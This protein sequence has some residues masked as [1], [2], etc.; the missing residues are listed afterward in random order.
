MKKWKIHVIA[1]THW[2]REWFFSQSRAN[3]LFANNIKDIVQVLN[4][5]PNFNSFVLDGQ[6]SVLNDYFKEFKTLKPEIEKLAKAKRLLLGP[7]YSQPDMFSSLGETIIRNLEQGISI[8]NDLGNCLDIAY[9]PDSFGFNANLPQ[10]F[11]YFD[12]KKMIF[13]RGM[14]KEDND[15]TIFFN[16][17]GIDGSSIPA[18]CY[19]SGYWMFSSFFPYHKVTK[20]NL[21]AEAKIIFSKALP[22]LKAIKDRSSDTKQQILFP[23]GQDESP[24]V[25]LLPELI[26][27]LN[28]LD[29]ENEWIMSDFKRFFKAL[30]STPKYEISSSL[31]WPYVARIHRTITTSRYDIK[32][33]FRENEN[34]IYHQLEPLQI[35]YRQID[36]GYQNSD[37]VNE[38]LKK[39]LSSQAHDSLGSCNSDETNQDIINRL[40]QAKA[41]IQAE[42]DI[43]INKIYYRLDLNLV[44]DLLVFNLLPYKRKQLTISRTINHL[45]PKITITGASV[46]DVLTI[47]TQS[48]KTLASLNEYFEHQ[49]SFQL[50][51]VA[52]F[53][54]QV[55]KIIPQSKATI[56]P[57]TIPLDVK[58]KI[59]INEKRIDYF[60]KTSKLIEN[61]FSIN[62]Y[63]DHGD[64]YDFSPNYKGYDSRKTSSTNKIIQSI[65]KDNLYYC[66]FIHQ[67]NYDQNKQQTFM[68][69]IS[70]HGH[71]PFDLKITTKNQ[72]V[73][74]KWM[75][76]FNLDFKFNQLNDIFATQ[77]LAL[78]NRKNII[79]LDWIK[80]GYKENPAL[81]STNDGLIAVPKAQKFSLLT[82]ANNEYSIKDNCLTITLFR[83]YDYLGKANLAWRPGRLSGMHMHTPDALLQKELSFKF[84]F[85]FNNNNYPK[86]LNDWFFQPLS[87]YHNDPN[88][89]DSF[90]DRFIVNYD[91]DKNLTDFKLANIEIDPNFLISSFRISQTKNYELR[92]AN[93]TKKVKKFTLLINGKT[94]RFI[95]KDKYAKLSNKSVDH[96]LLDTQKFI[97]I[98]FK[99]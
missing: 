93:L 54:Y 17:K 85:G 79:E 66:K 81:L 28:L 44:T 20:N 16:W 30:P 9:L 75:L 3:T 40:T 62:P 74:T 27:I 55:L 63:D 29:V 5:H 15:K 50:N 82:F 64:G 36:A 84:Q 71:Q 19:N 51:D 22:I 52:P 97:T 32:Q 26:E 65:N 58:D 72:S 86:L 80:K 37:V 73:L 46:S 35:I 98:N 34:L 11:N 10:I 49:I 39:L 14:K 77:S 88:R 6:V 59:I 70:R 99:L 13:W 7:W 61:I 47:A 83:A 33:L 2:D 45:A 94:Q 38:A 92:I 23:F 53:S 42:I 31:I 1:H 91:R 8:A 68:I 78:M 25:A 12:L 24:I 18:Y 89:I 95:I 69:E 57:T 41:I 21:L 90:D 87:Y 67:V 56:L 4:S 60:D 48:K 76:E 96:Y 43:I